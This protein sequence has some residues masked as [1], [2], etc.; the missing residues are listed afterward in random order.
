MDVPLRD[1][2]S[3]YDGT[4]FNQAQVIHEW[5]CTSDK[6]SPAIVSEGKA[7]KI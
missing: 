7:R 5:K 2:D 3:V 4:E 1:E 6:N